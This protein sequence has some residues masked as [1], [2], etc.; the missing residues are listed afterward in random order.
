MSLGDLRV[1]GA[2]PLDCPDTC[3]WVVTVQDGKAVKMRGN[4]DHP[5]TRGALCV[6]VNR[7]LEHTQAPD[8]ILHP[9]RRIGPKGSGRF[10]RISWDEAL[11][12]ISVR[13]RGIVDEHGGEAIWPYM[14]TGTL[15][16]IQGSEGVVHGGSGTF[17]GR[18]GTT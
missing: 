5:Y 17:S 11:E 6:K 9:M 14:G 10:E 8:R 18:P 13:L 3:S 4:P 7:Y 1:L 16:Y 2:C 15:G 12:E